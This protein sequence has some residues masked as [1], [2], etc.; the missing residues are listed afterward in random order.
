MKDINTNV[1]VWGEGFQVDSTQDF[2]NFTPK[3]I[4]AFKGKDTPDI[5]DAAFGWYHEA[6]IDKQGKLYV[7][8]KAKMTS[9]KVTEIKDGARGDL[10]E[11]KSIKGKVI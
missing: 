8:S 5:V 4:L 10:V 2:S 7:C 3:K 1:Y 11:V 9:V 6:Y